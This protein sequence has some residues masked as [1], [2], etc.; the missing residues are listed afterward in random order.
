MNAQKSLDETLE[1]SGSI[2]MDSKLHRL[3]LVIIGQDMNSGPICAWDHTKQ[4][5]DRLPHLPGV[6]RKPQLSRRIPCQGYREGLA[7]TRMGCGNIE[8]LSDQGGERQ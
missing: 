1:I 2:A 8:Y 5:I 7:E 6:G 3:Y 4:Q